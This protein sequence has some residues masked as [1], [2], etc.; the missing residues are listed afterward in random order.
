M[1]EPHNYEEGERVQT[2]ESAV[3]SY[4]TMAA[5][6]GASLAKTMAELGRVEGIEVFTVTAAVHHVWPNFVGICNST[7]VEFFLKES[8]IKRMDTAIACCQSD[9][10]VRT[11]R[12]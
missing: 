11:A 3:D 4:D 10:C 6:G 1:P 7:G 12:S 9:H 5:K 2:L 8:W